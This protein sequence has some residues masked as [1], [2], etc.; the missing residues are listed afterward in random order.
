MLFQ[1]KR[2]QAVG[3]IKEGKIEYADAMTQNKEHKVVHQDIS[4]S[5]EK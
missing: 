5:D 3:S 1:V 4:I 2:A